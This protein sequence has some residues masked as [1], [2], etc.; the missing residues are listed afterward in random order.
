MSRG[1]VWL[2]VCLSLAACDNSK[3]RSLS[4][5]ELSEKADECRRMKD[6]AP[7]LVQMCRSVERECERRERELRLYLCG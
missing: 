3:M 4:D 7:I 6:P 5:I 1:G 2:M